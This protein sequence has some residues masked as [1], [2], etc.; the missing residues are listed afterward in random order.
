MTLPARKFHWKRTPV[1]WTR[2]ALTTD[3]LV[4]LV[5]VR[6]SRISLAA[7]EW[8][9][10]TVDILGAALNST[11]G[12]QVVLHMKGPDARHGRL[13]LYQSGLELPAPQLSWRSRTLPEGGYEIVR[14]VPLS[15]LQVPE[16]STA[17]LF[18]CAVTLMP[19]STASVEYLTLFRSVGAFRYNR[20]D[21]NLTVGARMQ[22]VP[23]QRRPPYTTVARMAILQLRAMRGS[24]KM[25]TARHY[26]AS[27][28]TV[29]AWL[30]RADDVSLV[31]T[32]TPVNRFPDFVRYAVQQIKLFCPTLGKL[33]I[34]DK[35]ARVRIH[36]GKPTVEPILKETPVGPPDPTNDNAG[37]QSK[38]VS[39]Y[40]GHT[41]NADLAAVPISGEFWTS[42]L[43]NAIRQ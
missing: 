10:V 18:E 42:W 33:K 25:E 40:P 37:R 16:Q 22:R 3:K 39:K 8:P 41:W 14:L 32:H 7:T 29:R 13:A 27:D 35:L 12:R 11:T 24:N 2:L 6:D 5:R 4:V 26:F 17:F 38:I 28:D 9:E 15:L 23:P 21:A 19:E 1:R 20:H 34:A 30:R 43:P 31:D 36:I